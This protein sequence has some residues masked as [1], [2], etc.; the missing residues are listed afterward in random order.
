MNRGQL[1]VI[2][3]LEGP[4]QRC[5][6]LVARW[7]GRRGEIPRPH[8]ECLDAYPDGTPLADTLRNGQLDHT[9][10]DWLKSNF[11]KANSKSATGCAYFRKARASATSTRPVPNTS[12]HHTA[13]HPETS[14]PAARQELPR[15]TRTLRRHHPRDRRLLSDHQHTDRTENA[16]KAPKA[17]TSRTSPLMS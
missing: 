16:T 11:Y 2:R 4:L 13:A 7:S 1:S 6:L 10:I 3:T 17:P 14:R 15:P 9:A 12:P 8:L 5:A